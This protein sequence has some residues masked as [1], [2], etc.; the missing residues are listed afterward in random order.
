MADI[1]EHLP[2]SFPVLQLKEG[3]EIGL[4]PRGAGARVVEWCFYKGT[5]PKARDEWFSARHSNGR[6]VIVFWKN[7]Q[8][9]L[10]LASSGAQEPL[11]DSPCKVCS[12]PCN[13]SERTCWFCGVPSPV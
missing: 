3:Q 11:K 4:V 9:L 7:L 2:A 5:P 10:T 6:Q 12:R 1:L 13:A 8:A